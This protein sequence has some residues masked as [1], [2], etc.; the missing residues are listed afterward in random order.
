F[1]PSYNFTGFLIEDG[2]V[3][4]GSAETLGNLRLFA[5]GSMLAAGLGDDGLTSAPML[6]RDTDTRRSITSN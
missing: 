6:W 3:G 1:L 2:S 4:L 5:D